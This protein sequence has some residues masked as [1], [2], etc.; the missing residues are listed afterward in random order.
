MGRGPVPPK[1]ATGS[2]SSS[3]EGRHKGRLQ[4]HKI[5]T[6]PMPNTSVV[7]KDKNGNVLTKEDEQLNRRAEHF[8]EILH[9][10][11]VAAEILTT[12]QPLDMKRAYHTSTS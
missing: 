6:G 8:R 10:D 4:N 1:C 11:E 2:T 3:I 9:T 5:P 7:V 12:E